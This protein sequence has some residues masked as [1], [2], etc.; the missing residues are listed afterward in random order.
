MPKRILILEGN[1]PDICAKQDAQGRSHAATEY[2]DSL[3]RYVPDLAIDV[4]RPYFPDYAPGAIDFAAYDGMVCT[5]SGVDWSA[6]DARAKPFLDAY[7]SAFAAGMPVL[8][9]CWGLQLGA[10]A[11]GGSVHW[12][13]SGFEGA[14]ASGITL[15]EAGKAHPFHQGRPERF[16]VFCAHR[17]EV[18]E[19]PSGA[20][21]T[22]GNAHS[23]VQ[24]MIYNDGATRFWGIQYHPEVGI[25]TAAG[26]IERGLDNVENPDPVKRKQADDYRTIA[27]GGDATGA[28][29]AEH[30][31]DAEV[32]DPFR[33]GAELR[34]WLIHAVGA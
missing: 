10:V 2:G 22:A 27:R 13:P 5:G 16:D 4:A 20:I 23:P 3:R 1:T 11:L 34:N 6:D 25:E 17:D 32:T 7:A 33:H 31:L 29:A 24:G 9:S 12:S 18:K 8:G 15:T 21:L 19:M 14:L 28:L 26:W 30:G